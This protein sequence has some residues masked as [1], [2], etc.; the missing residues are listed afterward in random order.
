MGGTDR[1]WTGKFQS[2]LQNRNLAIWL[3]PVLKAE[4][5]PAGVTDLGFA[6]KISEKI[7]DLN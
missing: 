1:S 3:D 5:L 7:F 2:T 6:D 4:Q